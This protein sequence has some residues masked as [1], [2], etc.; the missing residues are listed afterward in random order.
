V[1][2]NGAGGWKTHK[3]PDCTCPVCSAQRRKAEALALAARDGRSP[4]EALFVSPKNA[5]KQLNAD[6]PDIVIQ[7]RTAR[8]RILQWM[9]LR[10][11]D[12]SRTTA[13][14]AKELGI[15][16][17]TLYGII[18]RA[19]QEGW[20]KF[21]DP[22]SRMDHEIVP[23]IMDNYV[24]LLNA[25]DKTATIEGMKGT[26]FKTYQDAKG[27]NDSPQTVLALKIETMDPANVK[28]V[29]GHVVGKPR[30]LEE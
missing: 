15:V 29:T 5:K 14:I 2:N 21:E 1:A 24:K 28:V 8:D 4:N 27:I 30:E 11:K 10:A 12:P 18:T 6:L 3:N 20:L 9:D 26:A 7:G 25:E 13:D 23:K 17:H 22:M 19:T 16:P